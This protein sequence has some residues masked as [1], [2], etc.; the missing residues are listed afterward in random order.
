M[1]EIELEFMWLCTIQCMRLIGLAK[2][3]RGRELST[4]VVILSVSVSVIM[5]IHFQVIKREHCMKIL[6]IRKY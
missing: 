3:M 5:G 6:I 1:I 4:L 2:F